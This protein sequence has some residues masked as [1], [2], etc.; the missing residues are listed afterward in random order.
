MRC[1]ALSRVR[2]AARVRD[3]R[4]RRMLHVLRVQGANAYALTYL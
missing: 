3:A 2:K 1:P 4:R